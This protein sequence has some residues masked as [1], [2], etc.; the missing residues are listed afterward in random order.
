MAKKK[1]QKMNLRQF[2]DFIDEKIS[3][4]EVTVMEGLLLDRAFAQ[5]KEEA[6]PPVVE[7]TKKG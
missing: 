3:S 4:G 7:D 6:P 2:G 1:I 5:V